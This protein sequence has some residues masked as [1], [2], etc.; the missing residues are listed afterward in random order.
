MS[1][2]FKFLVCFLIFTQSNLQTFEEEKKTFFVLENREG[3]GMF[4]MFT[5]VLALVASYE[6]GIFGG[7]EVD[8]GNEGL[9]WDQNKGSNWWIYYCEPISLGKKKNICKDTYGKQRGMEPHYCFNNRIEAFNLI[10]K[11]IRF[12]PHIVNIVKTFAN[13]HFKENYVIAIHYR[14][15]DAPWSSPAY[16]TYAQKVKEIILTSNLKN[17][18]I[19]IAADEQP[20]I[21]YME[22]QF[23][24]HVCFQK[25][26]LRST[27]GGNP[28][29]F[30]FSYNSYKKGEEALVDCLLL[31]HGDCLL[32]A[33]SNL[34]QWAAMI[35]PYSP[36][37]DM[38]NK[39]PR[40]FHQ[41]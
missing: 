29:H 33:Y 41:N 35:N 37:I 10:N 20:F 38:T 27:K 6:K 32:L 40:F 17:Y 3:A 13:Q 11:Y 19:F 7:I 25:G 30:N 5:D 24:L 4:S 21:E 28:L 9:Y 23:P 18:K 22:T 26:V 36:V 12:K 39:L 16:E 2:F 34:S 14:G 1:F 31:S 8:F 15:T